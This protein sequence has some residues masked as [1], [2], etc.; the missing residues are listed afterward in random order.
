[1]TILCCLDRE[2]VERLS[3]W[4]QMLS[5]EGIR[6]VAEVRIR[7]EGQVVYSQRRISEN[8]MSLREAV[9]CEPRI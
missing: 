5:P 6:K 9:Q 4:S 7:V 2:M 1:M 8:R 3:Q